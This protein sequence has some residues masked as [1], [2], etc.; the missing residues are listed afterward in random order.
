MHTVRTSDIKYRTGVYS[1]HAF[2]CKRQEGGE[3]NRG[4]GSVVLR[5]RRRVGQCPPPLP[6]DEGREQGLFETRGGGESPPT[7]G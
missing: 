2:L 3:Q 5:V 6:G 1:R 4:A 7:Q